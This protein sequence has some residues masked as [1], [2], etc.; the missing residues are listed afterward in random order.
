M[1]EISD[2]CYLRKPWLA[3]FI[4]EVGDTHVSSV[5]FVSGRPL[6]FL[7]TDLEISFLTVNFTCWGNYY[8]FLFLHFK[9]LVNR[10][11]G[12]IIKPESNHLEWY[13]LG[14][15]D[16]PVHVVIK[17][18]NFVILPPDLFLVTPCFFIVHFQEIFNLIYPQLQFL[19]KKTMASVAAW[20]IS[21]FCYYRFVLFLCEESALYYGRVTVNEGWYKK[22]DMEDLPFSRL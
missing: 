18:G 13:C 8:V 4:V 3:P 11:E 16:H 12:T 14:Y 7:L 21:I 10:L 19:S 22:F 9:A 15:L 6:R 17:K 1:S 2:S 5:G 20:I